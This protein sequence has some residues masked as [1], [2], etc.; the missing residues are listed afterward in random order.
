MIYTFSRLRK[1][2]KG[3]QKHLISD[4]TIEESA[5]IILNSQ[6][7]YMQEYFCV[8]HHFVFIRHTQEHYGYCW[9]CKFE[10]RPTDKI[11]IEDTN[12]KRFINIYPLQEH[13][14]IYSDSIRESQ[15]K[16]VGEEMKA[17]FSAR[18]EDGKYTGKIVRVEERTEPYEYVDFV[19]LFNINKKDVELKFG[20][21]SNLTYDEKTKKATSK[22]AQTLEEFGF[23]VDFNR[24]IT[25]ADIEKHFVGKQISSLV[26]NEK[27]K[28]GGGTF[29]VMK[30]MTPKL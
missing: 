28:K 1:T 4:E 23:V 20:C 18:I 7:P 5:Q 25:I 12:G 17:E 8:K 15:Y 29:A 11:M 30:T 9:Y 6:S 27:S 22:L 16:E 13:H 24:E 10:V 2:N 21:P 14:L 19:V 26:A 3:F